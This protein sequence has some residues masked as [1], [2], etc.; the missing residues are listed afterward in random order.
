MKTASSSTLKNLLELEAERGAIRKRLRPEKM[1]KKEDGQGSL[2]HLLE[3]FFEKVEKTDN[4]WR[5]NAALNKK[6][7]G[8]FNI[9]GRVFLS[10]RI[11]FALAGREIADGL[12]LDHTC[13]T[14]SCVNPDHL[15][16]VTNIENL[17]RS[18]EVWIGRDTCKKGHKSTPENA[19]EYTDF[20]GS[21]RKQCRKCHS[22]REGKRQIRLAQ[23][24]N[25]ETQPKL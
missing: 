7:Y 14:K 6:G 10:H 9:G 12:V 16:A 11:S 8:R 21:K 5:W 24:A 18:P 23:I 2:S 1:A 3:R 13:K 20:R 17:T 22:I 15:E 19:W 25:R 4:C